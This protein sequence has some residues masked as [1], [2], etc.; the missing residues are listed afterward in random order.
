MATNVTVNFPQLS[1][2]DAIMKAEKI[3]VPDGKDSGMANLDAYT[4]DGVPDLH[5]ITGSNIALIRL[6][7]GI[8]KFADM[9]KKQT[10]SFS[11]K[12]FSLIYFNHR[13]C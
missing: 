3:F 1:G 10:I 2:K 7:A 13:G 12:I 4:A 11:R 8:P 5:M 6:P 9:S